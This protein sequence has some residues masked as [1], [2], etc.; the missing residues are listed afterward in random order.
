MSEADKARNDSSDEMTTDIQTVRSQ[1][2]DKG[3]S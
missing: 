2:V 1:L 3:D